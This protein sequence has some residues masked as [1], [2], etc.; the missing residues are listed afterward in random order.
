MNRIDRL[1]AILTTLQ[2]KRVVRAEDLATRF[3]VSLRT[4]YRD[5]R[6]LEAGGVPIGA[7]AGIGYFL[8]EGYHIPPVM[9]T[10]EEARAL[11]LA[12]KLVANMTDKKTTSNF[13]SALTKVK[14]VLDSEK[15]EELNTLENDIVINPFSNKSPT[16]GIEELQLDQIK[17]ALAS[18]KIIAIEY[19]SGGKGEHTS[20]KLEPIGLCFYYSRWHLIAFCHM[21]ND[22][23]DFRLDR[24]SNL[25]V[26]DVAYSRLQRVSIQEYLEQLIQTTELE[27]CVIEI[28]KEVARYIDS[29]KFYMG[30]V[31]EEEKGNR[32]EMHFATAERSYFAHW[33]LMLGA[34]V[35]I[36]SPFILKIK[37]KELA[38][39]LYENYA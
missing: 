1:Q 34:N 35:T 13:D 9:F 4:I 11:L 2:S 27:L 3:E 39:R 28:D 17:S 7:E 14:A 25:Q 12:G 15:K 21:R 18:S 20:R 26:L 24:I 29:S 8:M 33:L 36:I 5:I 16:S 23:R 38:T 37:M 19:Y 31:K 6:S 30:V 32:I 10:H 22:Y